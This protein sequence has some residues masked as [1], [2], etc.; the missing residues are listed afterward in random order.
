MSLS[1]DISSKDIKSSG[2][3]VGLPARPRISDPN[4]PKDLKKEKRKVLFKKVLLFL[5]L[6]LVIA[7][8]YY[9]LGSTNWPTR[10]G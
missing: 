3:P 9:A 2:R 4:A 8:G 5:G 6:I 10:S 1:I 7:G